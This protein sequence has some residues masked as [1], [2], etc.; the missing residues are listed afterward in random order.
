MTFPNH[1][2]M[3]YIICDALNLPLSVKIFLALQ[4]I[5]PDIAGYA[6]KVWKKDYDLWNWYLEYHKYKWWMIF[7]PFWALHIYVDSFFHNSEGWTKNAI[8][9]EI[10]SWLMY[11]MYFISKFYRG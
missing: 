6:E 11:V 5:I 10:G 8:Y 9:F 3:S 7:T 1:I 4:A 2:I